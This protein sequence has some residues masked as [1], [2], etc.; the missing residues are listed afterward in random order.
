MQDGGESGVVNAVILVNCIGDD[1][2]KWRCYVDRESKVVLF[3]VSSGGG[4]G[5]C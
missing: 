4:G 2:V 1:G 5:E 3:L